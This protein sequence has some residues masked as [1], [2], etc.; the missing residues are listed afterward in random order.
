MNRVGLMASGLLVLSLVVAGP[1]AAQPATMLNGV[2]NVSMSPIDALLAPVIAVQ[3][4]QANT[5]ETRI[6]PVGKTIA[7]GIGTPWVWVLQEVLTGARIVSGLSEIGLGLVLT[8]VSLF[9]DVPERQLFDATTSLPMVD[10]EGAFDIV[11]GA[12]YIATS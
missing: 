9:K 10:H 7:Y 11:I 1:A 2:E 3:T 5:S 6:G 4:I 8:P 12:H